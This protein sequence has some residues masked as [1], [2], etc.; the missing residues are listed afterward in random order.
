MSSEKREKRILMLSF[1]TGLVFAIAE[2]IYAIYS[3][4]Q[5]VLMDG[6]Y[7]ST[8]L[9][10][11][12]LILFLTPLFHKPLSEEHPYGFYQ[13]ESIFIII[14]SFM[15]ISVTL[16]V[17]AEIVKTTF[18][19]GN[20]VDEKQISIFQIIVGLF[21]CVVFLIMKKMSK[22]VISP[23]VKT[24]LLGWKIDIAYS[25]GLSFAFFG[26]GFL[27]KTP[28]KF[29]APYFDSIIAVVIMVCTLPQTIKIL[30]NAIRDVFLFSPDEETVNGIKEICNNILERSRL[31]S[32]YFDVTRTGRRLW[33]SIYFT[34]KVKELRVDTLKEI[35]DNLNKELNKKYKNCMCELILAPNKSE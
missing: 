11:I 4:S 10:F 21:C 35:T 22:N 23:T 12:A 29:I 6:V 27:E 30:K 2:F 8:E 14:K 18:T 17:L 32:K 13:V 5:S 31:D 28:L 16:G 25:L 7:D 1:C 15:M 19:G 24:E 34:T 9:I 20:T 3:H 33:V 26:A